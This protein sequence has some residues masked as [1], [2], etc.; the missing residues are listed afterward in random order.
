MRD[1]ATTIRPLPP[2]DSTR[3]P[4]TADD[5]FELRARTA[6]VRDGV[7][8]LSERAG[9]LHARVQRADLDYRAR[10][11]AQSDPKDLLAILSNEL[12]MSWSLVA[13]LVRVS[14]TA[15]RKWRQDGPVTPENRL[16][17]A[18]AIAF[19]EALVQHNPRITDAALW[20]E[21]PLTT[22]TV[23]R[24]ATLFAAGHAEALLDLAAD[25]VSPVNVLDGFAHDWRTRFP[26]DRAFEV[27]Q[28]PD[29]LPSIVP[30]T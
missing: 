16:R 3:A 20:L 21:T 28:A 1:P 8:R 26:A 23:L 30:R 29:G 6:E 17:I 19:C 14:P 13:E 7:D 2:R 24:P 12:G 10:E 18:H 4:Q 11:L 9:E 22:T 5:L 15:V 27:I 25:R